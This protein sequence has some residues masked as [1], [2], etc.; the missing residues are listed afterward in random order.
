M[1]SSEAQRSGIGGGRIHALLKFDIT[2]A[3][4]PS[5][6]QEIVVS[7]WDPTGQ[8]DQPRGKQVLNPHFGSA[9]RVRRT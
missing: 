4:E 7:V 8:G 2:A 3:L 5:G 6:P 9:W 1:G